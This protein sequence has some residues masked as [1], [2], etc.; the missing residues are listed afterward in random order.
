MWYWVG[1][2]RLVSKHRKGKVPAW[3]YIE[4]ETRRVARDM[5]KARFGYYPDLLL[6]E[7]KVT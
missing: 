2:R 4:A 6:K 1:M 7:M 5:I 3:G